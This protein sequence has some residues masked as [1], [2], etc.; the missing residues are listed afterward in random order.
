MRELLIILFSIVFVAAIEGTRQLLRWQKERRDGE[1]RRRLQAVV[2][3][4]GTSQGG[5]LL[6]DR[7]LARNPAID[8]LLRDL[9]VA[10]RLEILLEQADS[11]LTVAQLMGWTGA[12]AFAGPVLATAMRLGVLVAAAF[13]LIGLALPVVSLTLLRGRRSNKLSEQL[14]EALEMMSRSL[15]AGHAL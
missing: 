11:R 3:G 10:R 13:G 5:S 1:L 4:G 12:L 7:R 8:A 6:R 14:P 2:G 15:R 9:P